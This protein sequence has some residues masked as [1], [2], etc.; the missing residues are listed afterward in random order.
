MDKRKKKK[1][2]GSALFTVETLFIVGLCLILG[3]VGY[4]TIRKMLYHRYEFYLEDTLDFV[5]SVIDVDDLEQCMETGVKSEKYQELQAFLDNYKDHNRISYV[6]VIKPLNDSDN[7]N[8]MNVIAGLST[9]EKENRPEN[10]VG[11]N[12]LTG[13]SYTPEVAK[14]Y[15]EAADKIGEYSFFEDHTEE[16]GTAYTA[17]LPLTDSSGKYVAELCV[18]IQVD[19]IGET[20]RNYVLIVVV[21]LIVLCALSILGNILW[22]RKRI[23]TPLA[24][25]G[26]SMRLFADS[27][28]VMTS[29]AIEVRDPD[30]HTGDEIE[31][32][33]VQMVDMM[34]RLNDFVRQVLTI[35][36][37]KERIGAELDI[38]TK[39]QADMLPKD[40]PK[41]EDLQIYATMV[42]ARE[43]GG[44][45]YDFFMIDDDHVGLVMADVSGKGI[46]AAMFMIIA[47]TLL[48]IR[49]SS[50]GTP[51]EMLWD[52]NNTLCADNPSELFVTVWFG[53]LTL[54]SGELVSANA[55]HEYPVLLHDGG[56]YELLKKDENMPPLAT[57][58]NIQYQDETI[59]LHK[60]DRL[61]LYTDGVPEA[62]SPDSRRFGLNNM[63]TILNQNRD[64]S[65]EEL[66]MTL[67]KKIN[68]FSGEDNLFDDV[69][70]MSIVWN[71]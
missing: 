57:E 29:D 65:P 66:L 53:I 59:I 37:E 11:L 42:P 10:E 71:G 56:E 55:G 39:M 41:R 26:E 18:D 14:L 7:D 31:T 20:L 36:A 46:P 43:M 22:L 62:K 49:T 1:K 68:E 34:N 17:I 5:S 61:F 52:I 25:L 28:H 51:A 27:S 24:S 35:T 58:M 4:F 8:I 45:F 6:Y 2:L 47:K 50:P 23:L 33:S 21:V 48:N 12:E 9:W 15:L 13:N 67:Q 44:D 40:F 30:I 32:L 70:M 38:A 60:G 69:T 16:W 54:S 19:D 3:L 63:L 64:R